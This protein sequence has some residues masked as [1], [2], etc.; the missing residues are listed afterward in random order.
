MDWK[1]WAFKT[2]NTAAAGSASMNKTHLWFKICLISC[3]A[4]GYCNIQKF[5]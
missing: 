2:F 5:E 4:C 3:L 1:G